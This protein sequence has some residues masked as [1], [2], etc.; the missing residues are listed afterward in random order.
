MG[1]GRPGRTEFLK[2]Y[3]P[4]YPQCSKSLNSGALP[5]QQCLTYVLHMFGLLMMASTCEVGHTVLN[6]L[7]VFFYINLFNSHNN[8]PGHV[9]HCSHFMEKEIE[10]QRSKVFH[11]RPTVN[12]KGRFEP[13]MASE[14]T[15]LTLCC[16][17]FM[18]AHHMRSYCGLLEP[19]LEEPWPHLVQQ[20]HS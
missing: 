8:L 1:E 18:K 2:S 15:L 4:V 16:S 12:L 3:A 13:S 7:L 6:I 17:S 5:V 10:A 14:F 11:P 9:L 20:W 19:K